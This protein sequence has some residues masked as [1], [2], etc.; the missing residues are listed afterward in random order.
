MNNTHTDSPPHEKVAHEAYK[1]WERHGRPDGRD[2]EFWF[3]A[4]RRLHYS[5]RDEHEPGPPAAPA[6][7]ASP[8]DLAARDLQQKNEA[9]A[10]HLSGGHESP[11]SARPAPPGKPLWDKPH[12]KQG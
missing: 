9:R 10:S 6:R 11:M 1:L 4:E 7:L 3:E 2:A 12:S 8:D 5:G